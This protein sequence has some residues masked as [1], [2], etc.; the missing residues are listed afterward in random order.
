ME[1]TQ[2]VQPLTTRDMLNHALEGNP[3]NMASVFNDLVMG[4]VAAAVADRKADLAQTMFADESDESDD[5]SEEEDEDLDLSDD[6]ESEQQ[7]DEAED[8]DTESNA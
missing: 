1:D 5:E 4:K 8:E 7:E 2:E 6:E 3:A